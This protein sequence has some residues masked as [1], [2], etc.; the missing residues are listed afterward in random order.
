MKEKIVRIKDPTEVI[1]TVERKK[2]FQSKRDRA[3]DILSKLNFD[4]YVYGSVARGDVHSD[5][6]I[7]IVFLNPLEMFLIE[8]PLTENNYKIIS[9]EIIMANPNSV[10]KAHLE[11]EENTTVSVPLFK[12][13]VGETEFYRFG[14]AVDHNGIKDGLRVPGVTKKLLFIEPTDKG[15]IESSVTG[16]EVDV[17]K[18]L[19]L[20]LETVIERVRVLTRRD[21]I[22]RTGVYLREHVDSESSFEATWKYLSDRDP[23]LKRQSKIRKK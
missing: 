9:R 23:I 3:V 16:N 17:S 15:H 20:K 1:Y 19:G 5:S 13:K 12:P 2:I 11:L 6:D 21:R 18:K 8:V 4:G 7:D 22:G 14:G 10:P